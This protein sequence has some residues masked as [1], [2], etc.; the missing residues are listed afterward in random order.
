MCYDDRETANN[1]ILHENGFEGYNWKY[2][3]NRPSTKGTT[4]W[5]RCSID[6][7]CPVKVNLKINTVTETC[8]VFI[9]ESKH[10]H[11]DQVVSTLPGI[12]PE[13]KGLILEYDALPIPPSAM[14]RNLREKTENIP[15]LSQLNNFLRYNRA[16]SNGEVGTSMCLN[17]L[18]TFHEN[19]KGIP[20]DSDWL[21]CSHIW[22]HR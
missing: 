8:R 3:N 1:L 20:N 13:V 22:N 5:Y 9:G 6:P 18:I 19:N 10:K 14:I 16:H 11:R 21:Q 2:L 4:V 7:T 17:D 15:T 12:R